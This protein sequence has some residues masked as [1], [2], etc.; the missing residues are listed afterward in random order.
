[1]L[2]KARSGMV[3]VGGQCSLVLSGELTELP[4]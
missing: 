1:M 4:A 2:I 3:Q